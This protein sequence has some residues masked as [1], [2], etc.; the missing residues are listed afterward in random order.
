[1]K[2]YENIY[3][4]RTERGMSQEA[5]AD[6]LDV[7]RQSVSKWE[8]AASVP[9]LDRLMKMC[10]IFSVSLDELTGRTEP[11]TASV[12][13]TA[14]AGASFSETQYTAPPSPLY[15]VRRRPRGQTVCGIILTAVSLITLIILSI[16]I[17]FSSVRAEDMTVVSAAS[18]FVGVPA[19]VCLACGVICLSAKRH[20]GLICILAV[21][22]GAAVFAFLLLISMQ[23]DREHYDGEIEIYVETVV[24]VTLPA[25]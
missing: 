12:N 22:I 21:Y 8:T 9:D 23:T 19:A 5:L 3:R 2:L 6:M 1:M 18:L 25:E 13:F 11:E 20:A 14:D 4:L 16:S 7:S 15:E 24:D 10:D 17:I